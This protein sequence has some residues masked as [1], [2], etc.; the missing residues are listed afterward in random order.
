M[1]RRVS[2]STIEIRDYELEPHINGEYCDEEEE[3]RLISEEE[4]QEAPDPYHNYNI[5]TTPRTSLEPEVRTKSTSKSGF[6]DH[7]NNNS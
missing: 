3:Y 6:V 1:T 2:C 4:K 5:P 7:S